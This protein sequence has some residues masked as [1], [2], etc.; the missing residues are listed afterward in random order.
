[1]EE[2]KN[3]IRMVETLEKDDY[4]VILLRALE[5]VLSIETIEKNLKSDSCGEFID[6]F[7]E[8]NLSNYLFFLGKFKEHYSFKKDD[9]RIDEVLFNFFV[10][11]KS[12]EYLKRKLKSLI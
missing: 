5:S 1:M 12:M 4:S 6:T 8:H 10:E 11:E 9:L 2:K 7:R 3:L